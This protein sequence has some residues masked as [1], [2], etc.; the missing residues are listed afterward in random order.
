MRIF[1]TAGDPSADIHA[2]NLMAAIREH[3][4][5]VAFDG[6]G[7]PAMEMH[8]L[9]TLAP[10][11]NLAVSGYW[12][13]IKHL[14]F[15]R[16]LMHRCS[17]ALAARKYSVFIP[18]D[19]PGFNL[20]LAAVARR[21]QIPVCWYIAPQLWAWGK[22]RA[23]QL[24]RVVNRL[25]VVFPFEVEF[26]EQYGISTRFVGHPL[27]D[28][29]D[30][31]DQYVPNSVVVL[32]GSRRNELAH[33]VPLLAMVAGEVLSQ[34][35]AKLVTVP[36]APGIQSELLLPLA[37]AGATIVADSHAAL[38]SSAAGLI[39]AGTSTLEAAVMGLPFATFYKTSWASYQIGKH[40]INIS[41]VTMANHLLQRNVVHEFLQ[42]K[43]TVKA[44]IRELEDLLHN[45]ERRRELQNAFAEV[46]RLLG[47]SHERNPAQRA[48]DAVA[49]LLA[50]RRVL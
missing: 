45:H 23:P 1:I 19:Y 21:R 47:G 44:L 50:T 41:T 20:R 14:G 13:V 33:H 29:I 37:D 4:P 18:V 39:K 36:A 38:R 7:G 42:H 46:R 48:A 3:F 9:H 49:E 34:G 26:F 32:P 31:S 24:A 30:G 27:K 16:G 43:A 10:I 8:G 11:K 6:F 15:F 5:D 35:I 22:K 40:F 28:V 12:E 17:D 25:L 2:A